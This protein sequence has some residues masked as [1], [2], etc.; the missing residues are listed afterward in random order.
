MSNKLYYSMFIGFAFTFSLFI[1]GTD[2]KNITW[3]MVIEV[4]VG[5]MMV[6]VIRYKILMIMISVMIIDVV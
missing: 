6:R 2:V 3:M 4:V 5:M 1:L